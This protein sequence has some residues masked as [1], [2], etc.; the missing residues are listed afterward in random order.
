MTFTTNQWA[1][2]ALVLFLG[3]VLGL[4]SRSGS[5][6]WKRE[7]EEQRVRR[8]TAEERIPALNARIAELEREAA[9]RPVPMAQAAAT[10][11]V[12]ETV[13]PITTP[14]AYPHDA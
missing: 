3:W 12:A 6:R 8:E 5:G 2:L 7:A 11:P 1:I 14:P 13:N 9:A 10:T 4:A